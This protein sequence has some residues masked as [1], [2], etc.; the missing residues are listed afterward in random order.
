MDVEGREWYGPLYRACREGHTESVKLLVEAGAWSGVEKEKDGGQMDDAKD[1]AAKLTKLTQLFQGQGPAG[2]NVSVKLPK[3]ASVCG[4][5]HT[6]EGFLWF[7]APDL[8]LQFA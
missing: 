8:P 1:M 7:V 5:T 3:Q 4:S 2:N 6:F